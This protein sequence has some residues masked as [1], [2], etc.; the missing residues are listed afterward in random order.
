MIFKE[1]SV[2]YYLKNKIKPSETVFL[3]LSIVL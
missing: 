2:A 3:W 1:Y